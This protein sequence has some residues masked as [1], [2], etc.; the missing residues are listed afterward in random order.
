M[1]YNHEPEDAIVRAV[2]DTFDNDTVGAIVGATVGALHGRQGLPERWLREL[3][4]RTGEDDDRRFF[5]L[6][7]EARER[8]W[9][10]GDA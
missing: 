10:P 9:Q 2:N 1:R 6:L 3:S 4:G 5:Q 7:E 8:S